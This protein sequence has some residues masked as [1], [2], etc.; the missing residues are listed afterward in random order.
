MSILSSLCIEVKEIGSKSVAFRDSPA[1]RIYMAFRD[2]ASRPSR[3]TTIHSTLS[4]R[5]RSC[6]SLARK[7]GESTTSASSDGVKIRQDRT[8]PGHRLGDHP[9]FFFAQN[10]PTSRL[11]VSANT[12]QAPTLRS[13][14]PARQS[15]K[16]R[17]VTRA[18]LTTKRL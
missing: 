2:I 8:P 16:M 17:P 7:Y 5:R 18:A 14:Q 12:V 4:I 13:A 1:R 3:R 9:G 15:A 10:R 6:I 11:K